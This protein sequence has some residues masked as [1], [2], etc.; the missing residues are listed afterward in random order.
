MSSDPAGDIYFHFEFLAPCPLRTTQR[1][2]A[3]EIKHNHS[4][5]VIVV[6]DPKYDE[7]Y[8]DLYTYSR[9]IVLMT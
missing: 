1:N 5:V 7:S 9:S 2:H 4:L 8:K 3:N 6:L